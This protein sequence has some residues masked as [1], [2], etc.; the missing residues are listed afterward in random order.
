MRAEEVLPQPRGPENKYAWL[1]RPLSSA[2]DSGSVTCSCPTTSA[3][4]AGRYFRYKATPLGYPAHRTR[5]FERE[6]LQRD[7]LSVPSHRARA[8]QDHDELNKHPD[9]QANQDENTNKEERRD[10]AKEEKPQLGDTAAGLAQVEVVRSKNAQEESQQRGC[11]LGLWLLVH[12][13]AIALVLRGEIRR[14]ALPL[15][16]SRKIVVPLGV[17][18]LVALLLVAALWVALLLVTRLPALPMVLT[19]LIA[20]WL[21]TLVALL[22]VAVLLVAVLLVTR[23][24]ALPLLLT[25]V[26]STILA[27]TCRRGNTRRLA[28]L[29]RLVILT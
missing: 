21:T 19:V 28:E 26:L 5:Q 8:H 27:S 14:G 15:L 24:P 1:M 10:E 29:A 11:H 18:T 20:L 16:L 6:L 3:N 12:R 13:H 7:A 4:E 25:A 2:T 23:L 9:L 22:L 17:A